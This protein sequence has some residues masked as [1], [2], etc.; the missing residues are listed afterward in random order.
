MF[1]IIG[2]CVQPCNQSWFSFVHCTGS[3]P[4]KRENLKAKQTSHTV[5][6][7]WL[8]FYRIYLNYP[9]NGRNS[10]QLFVLYCGWFHTHAQSRQVPV[11]GRNE[12]SISSTG[13]LL[14]Q[15]HQLGP[16]P[17]RQGTSRH[18]PQDPLQYCG[19]RAR[20]W[21]PLLQPHEAQQQGNIEQIMRETF[22]LETNLNRVEQIPIFERSI[23]EAKLKFNLFFFSIGFRLHTRLQGRSG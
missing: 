7:S 9:L 13:N 1:L 12:I 3:T 22:I 21:G 15:R 11:R 6:F 2:N 23:F 10:L 17:R 19:Q 8:L 4:S 14:H 20:Y 18:Q 16:I 5:K